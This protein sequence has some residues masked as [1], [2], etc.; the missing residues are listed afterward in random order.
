LQQS[1]E[2]LKDKLTQKLGIDFQAIFE[3]V[4]GDIFKEIRFELPR[5]LPGVST[6]YV[7]FNLQNVA[8]DYPDIVS[9]IR[10]IIL[11]MI[12]LTLVRIVL[13][14]LRQY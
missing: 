6:Q 5:F 1:F 14:T 13:V 7:V 3:N 4:T 10:N 12:F 11:A 9:L 2:Q 8:R